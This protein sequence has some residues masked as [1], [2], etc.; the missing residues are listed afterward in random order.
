M[1]ARQT[2]RR[3]AQEIGFGIVD[4]TKMVTAASELARNTLIYGHGGE[5]RWEVLSDGTKT[6][7]ATALRRS[8]PRDRG[9]CSRR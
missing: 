4:Q 1:L 7:P 2:V 3:L 8:G 9:P 6:R 5:M